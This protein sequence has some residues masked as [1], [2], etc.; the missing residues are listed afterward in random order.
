[1]KN[2]FLLILILI[3]P[4]FAFSLQKIDADEYIVKTGD[5]FYLNIQSAT[6][7]DTVLIVLPE[8]FVNIGVS[9]KA[10]EVAGSTLS[11]SK[12]KILSAFTSEL[13]NSKITLDLMEMAPFHYHLTGAVVRPGTYVSKNILT[14]DQVFSLAGGLSPAAR[15]KINIM[16]LGQ[17]RDYDL[18]EFYI[19]GNLSQNPFVM[20]NDIVN[21]EFAKSYLKVFTNQTAFETTNIDTIPEFFYVDLGEKK[22]MSKNEFMEV[23]KFKFLNS[24]FSD[25]SVVRN[26]NILEFSEIKSLKHLDEIY[27]NNESNY[28][29]VAGEV[30]VPNQFDYNPTFDVK[31]YLALA[32]GVLDTGNKN[33][34]I[35]L[36]AD[37]RKKRFT[38]QKL[39]PNDTII[40]TKDFIAAFN[41]YVAPL[42]TIGSLAITYLQITK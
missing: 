6:T 14:L 38:G 29:F 7:I 27:F 23:M 16:R 12:Q 42:V 37:G 35:I 25:Y 24:N 21:V 3:L 10:I 9:D 20:D 26:R 31:N 30:K 18:R 32:G 5:T 34:I 8:G 4:A 28:I 11:E 19:N 17:S 15:T 22:E 13:K 39:L 1:M 33:K 40:V 41:K 36:S 2:R